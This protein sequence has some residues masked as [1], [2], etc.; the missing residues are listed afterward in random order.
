MK[1]GI[2]KFL[3]YDI[4]SIG[5]DMKPISEISDILESLGFLEIDEYDVN[6]EIDFWVK[7]R[8]E[9]GNTLRLTGSLWVGNFKLEK[10]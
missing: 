5:L 10:L 8:H 7:F 1:E 4:K 6:G 9:S 3:K 2:E